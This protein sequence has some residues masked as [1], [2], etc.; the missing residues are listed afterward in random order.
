MIIHPVLQ[1]CAQRV[2]P[3]QRRVSLSAQTPVL[4]VSFPA[5]TD[6]AV[7]SADAGFSVV[8]VDPI[9]H[10]WVAMHSDSVKVMMRFS[11]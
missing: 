3:H 2:S 1:P 8:F 6:E 11:R 9:E 4:F 10:L 7:E 5:L